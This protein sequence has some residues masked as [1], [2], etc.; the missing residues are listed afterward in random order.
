MGWGTPLHELYTEYV[1]SQ[2]IWFS[3]RFGQFEIGC[4]FCRF[5][6]KLGIVLER[7]SITIQ[8]NTIQYNTIQYNAMQF[9]TIQYNTIQYNTMQCNTLQYNTIHYNTIQYN[10]IQC[11]TIQYNTIQ[12]NTIQYN[13]IQCNTIIYLMSI[14]S[15]KVALIPKPTFHVPLIRRTKDV[16]QPRKVGLV[17]KR[18]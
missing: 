7:N 12:Y 9:I 18:I 8:Y 6:P 5:G 11:N 4:R 13:T 14:T 1:R 17:G 16:F 2:R 3:S 15:G 10:T